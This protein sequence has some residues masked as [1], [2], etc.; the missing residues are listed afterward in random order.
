MYVRR[1]RADK[2]TSRYRGSRGCS[3]VRWPGGW[4]RSP[5]PS[6]PRPVGSPGCGWLANVRS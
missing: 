6:G 5:T 4:T 2:T 3:T 1:R